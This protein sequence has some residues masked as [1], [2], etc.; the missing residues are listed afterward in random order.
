MPEVS[1]EEAQKLIDGWQTTKVMTL[2]S[3]AGARRG[4]VE[5]AVVIEDI[6]T[7]FT[8]EQPR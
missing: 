1:N 6:T 2:P 3:V 7:D 5:S 4:D 8:E